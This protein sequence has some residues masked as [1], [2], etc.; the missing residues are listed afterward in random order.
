ME[1]MRSN[2]A[3]VYIVGAGPGDKGLISVKGMNCIKNADL[4]VYDRLVDE[5]ILLNAKK[6]CKM[7]YVG[8]ESSNHT[9]KQEE[10]NQILVDFAKKNINVVRL[11]GGDPYVFGRGSERSEEH[12]SE[13]QSRQ[14]LVCRL[15]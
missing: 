4:I 2:M 12:T 9:M 10:I 15:L 3:R 13:L 7:I 1:K 14:Y 8:K 5:N 11:K 6:E